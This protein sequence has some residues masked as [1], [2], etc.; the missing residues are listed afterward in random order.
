[1][2]N[3]KLPECEFKFVYL[4]CMK[5]PFAEGLINELCADNH[6]KESYRIYIRKEKK[7]F[8]SVGLQNIFFI[9]E[10]R[11]GSKKGVFLRKIYEKLKND[12][13]NLSSIKIK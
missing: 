6:K 10:N 11:M 7:F 9:T 12:K 5:I 1:M 4:N 13:F 2:E 3:Q 8:N